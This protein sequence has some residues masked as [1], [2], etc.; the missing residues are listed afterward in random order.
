[1][2]HTKGGSP[3]LNTNPIDPDRFRLTVI[4]LEPS[5]PQ[6]MPRSWERFA[7]TPLGWLTDRHR[8]AIFPPRARLWLYLL[9]KTREGRKPVRLTNQMAV[10]IGLDRFAK[11]RA[12]AQLR[13]AGLVSVA[14][15]GLEAPVVTVLFTGGSKG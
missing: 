5:K 13:E 15:H 6:R 14:Q 1:M 9:I 7:R 4:P 3:L 12:L 10:E 2:R 8:D 11:A